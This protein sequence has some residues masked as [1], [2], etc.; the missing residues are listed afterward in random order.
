MWCDVFT[1]P[2][3][4]L[5][6]PQTIN[7][8][9]RTFWDLWLKDSHHWLIGYVGRQGR[10]HT[11]YV[12][13]ESVKGVE[14]E[15]HNETRCSLSK[16]VPFSCPHVNRSLVQNNAHFRYLMPIF[17]AAMSTPQSHKGAR[18]LPFLHMPAV[19]L[20]PETDELPHRAPRMG[21]Y[22]HVCHV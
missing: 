13:P 5:V 17:L 2:A 10:V 20:T 1:V 12:R 6:S 8:H 21:V 22:L 18:S 11:R 16:H 9:Q 14:C 4:V 19:C 7:S 3:C 15:V